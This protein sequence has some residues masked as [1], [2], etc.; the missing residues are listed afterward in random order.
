[1][2]IWTNAFGPGVSFL[3]LVLGLLFVLY[4]FNAAYRGPRPG[5]PFPPPPPGRRA[6]WVCRRPECRAENPPHGRF[7]RMC[8]HR[9]D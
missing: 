3:L 5:G 8:G 1:M 2:F 6:E 4:S 7:C 9:R